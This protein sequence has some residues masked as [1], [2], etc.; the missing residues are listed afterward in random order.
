[1][2]I[3]ILPRGSSMAKQLKI[4]EWLSDFLARRELDAPDGRHLFSYRATPEEFLILEEG[5]KQNMALASMRDSQNPLN[6]WKNAPGFNAVFVLYAAL[7]WQQK[8]EGTT[9]TY[10]VI[11]KGLDIFLAKPSLELRD[12]IV[13]GL[14]FWG[15]AKNTQGLAYLGSIAREAGLP[16]KLL[17]EN[18]GP[19]GHLL[20]SVL[21]EALRSGQSG[22]IITSWLASYNSSLPQSCRS[23]EIIALL[24]DSINA[25][26]DIKNSLHASTLGEALTELNEKD[27]D[28]RSRFPLPLYDDIARDLLN[29]LLEDAT[30]SPQASTGSPISASRCIIRGYGQ[31]WELQARLDMPPRMATG[32]GEDKPR[33]LSMRIMS[34]EKSFEAVLKKHAESD[35]YFFQQKQSIVFSGLEAMQEILI[36]YTAP[37]GFCQMHAC[38]GGMELDP[39]L[40]WIFEG[41]QYDYRFRQQGG[42]SVR[43]AVCYVALSPGWEVENAEDTGPLQ[44]TNRHVYRMTKSGHLRKGE[45][46]FFV[47]TSS[48]NGEECDWSLDNRFWDVEMLQP[49]LAFR[50]LPQPVVS[51]GETRKSPRGELLGKT[52]GMEKFAPLS[53]SNAATGITQVWFKSAGGASLRSRMLLLPAKASVSLSTNEEGKDCL[54]LEGWCAAAASLAESQKGLE[55]ACRPLRDSLE[56]TFKT[57]PGHVPPVTV[58]LQVYWKD[59]TQPACIRVPFPQTGARLFNAEGQEILS[60]RQICAQHLHG[61]RLHCFSTGVRH[62]ALRLS[63]P[64]KT[65]YYPLETHENGTVIRLMDWQDAFLEMLAMTDG[66]DS[67]VSLDIL[68]DDRK[69]AGW[70][71]ARYESC[72]IPEGTKAVLALPEYGERPLQGYDMKALLLNHPECAPKSLAETLRQD[73]SASG[74]WELSEALDRP[75]PWLIFDDTEGTSLRPMLWTVDGSEDETPLNSLQAAIAEKNSESRLQAF[76]SCIAVME[77]NL[78]VPEWKTLLEI[79]QHVRNLP[80]STL[81]VWSALLH[82]PR[83]M[84]MIALHPGISF[85]NVTSRICTELP[86]LWNFVSLQD[87]SAASQCIRYSFEGLFPGDTAFGFWQSHM[88]K[89]MENIG[90]CCPSVNTLMHVAISLPEDVPIL[91]RACPHFHAHHASLLFEGDNS[92][93]QKLLRRHADDEWPMA[94][95]SL[96]NRE[97]RSD[98]LKP[99][100]PSPQ[101]ARDSVLGLP[102]LL[103]FQAFDPQAAFIH[104]LPDQDTVFHI[105]EHLHF[106]ADWFEQA[107]SLTAYYCASEHFSIK[108]A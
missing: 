74:E 56:L 91:T 49:S 41:E 23:P 11:L 3:Y 7:C 69:V 85:E 102:I 35:F 87:W 83:I 47:R 18:R 65:L 89:A 88:Q 37:S 14:E 81:N 12:I 82:S 24:A 66:L 31:Q 72:L 4:K 26:L 78:D 93:M 60:N 42:G 40:P 21:R 20:H 104:F 39:E 53:T 44:D 67:R 52:S 86:F 95:A 100:L 98:G 28:W 48:L 17:A 77:H 103:M 38:P 92:E 25:I 10:D 105:R 84:A 96:S 73:G 13:S 34:G 5:L 90:S 51:T 36:R 63:L 61:L 6:L 30:S 108:D 1:M 107:S 50:G 19:V 57:R 45:L 16:Q 59:S 55:L 68:F 79:F 15:L 43:G 29:R 64:G 8:Y 106:D 27:P 58:D 75:G 71:V 80:L 101:G 2:K 54:N 76:L 62:T 22:S 46:A 97:R 94:F 70:S 33:L 99:L 9:W 32:L